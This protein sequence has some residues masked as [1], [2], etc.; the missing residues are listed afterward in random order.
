MLLSVPLSVMVKIM[1]ENSGELKWAA[2]LLGPSP[3][4]PEQSISRRS[5]DGRKTKTPPS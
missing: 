1:L 2:V 3:N 5:E 4:V